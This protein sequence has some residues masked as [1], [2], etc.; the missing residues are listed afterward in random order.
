M[1]AAQSHRQRRQSS[2]LQTE[3]AARVNEQIAASGVPHGG[4]VPAQTLHTNTHTHNPDCLA[5]KRATVEQRSSI[6]DRDFL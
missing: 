6:P 3:A 1:G 2:R 5:Q 4:G